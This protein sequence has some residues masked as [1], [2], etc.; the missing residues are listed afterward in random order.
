MI[1]IDGGHV[2]SKNIIEECGQIWVV[3]EELTRLISFNLII[4]RK[5]SIFL[6]FPW[7]ELRNPKN[8]WQNREVSGRKQVNAQVQPIY[9]MT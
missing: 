1:F 4:S 5:H 9:T 8:N 6:G 3:L 2:A 7:F